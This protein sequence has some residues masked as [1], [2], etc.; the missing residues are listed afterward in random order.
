M[1][2]PVAERPRTAART[3]AATVPARRR[4]SALGPTSLPTSTP[5]TRSTRKAYARRDDRQRRLLGGRPAHAAAPAGRARFVLT[6]MVLLVAGL[7]ATL[8]LSTAAAADSYRLQDARAQAR[9]LSQQSERLHREVAAMAAAPELARRAT[10]LGMVQVQDPARLVVLP[11]GS[12]AVVGEPRA[13]VAPPPPAP[14][15]APPGAPPPGGAQPSAHGA[16]TPQQATAGRRRPVCPGG[17]RTAPDGAVVGAAVDPAATSGERADGSDE[18]TGGAAG[19]TAA[20]G[21]AG[22]TAAGGAAEPTLA[23]RGVGPTDAGG[24]TGRAGARGASDPVSARAG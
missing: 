17:T 2:A 15:P 24:A 8:W 1:S 3:R 11:D 9:T 23:G 12:V 19:R 13:A 18:L 7:V 14:P 4:A 6:V 10:E 21:T 20:G 5:T 22:R 16:T